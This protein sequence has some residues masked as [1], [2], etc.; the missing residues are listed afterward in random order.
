[1]GCILLGIKSINSDYIR[2]AIY[3]LLE[4]K[5]YIFATTQLLL[6]TTGSLTKGF[7]IILLSSIGCVT[8][9]RAETEIL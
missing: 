6:M 7:D 4:I 8:I 5:L 1:M 2:K 3:E 9:K